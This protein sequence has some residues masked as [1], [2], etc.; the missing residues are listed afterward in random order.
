M[1]YQAII[2]IGLVIFML[3]LIL[4]LRSLKTPPTKSKV[5][6]D[7]PL[8]SV[9][10]PARDE[11]ANIKTCLESLQKQDY[12]NFEIL[13]LDDNSSDGT[14]DIVRRIAAT[15]D[16]I[17]L[18]EGKL[19]PKGWAGKSYACYQ[20]AKKAKGSWLLFTDA[21]TMHAPHTLRSSLAL[22]I[23]HNASLLS[24][25]PRQITTSLQQK[26]TIPVIYFIIMSWF[27]LWWLQRSGHPRPS[28]AIG[29]F[30]LFPTKAYW[31]CGGHKAVKTRIV[32]DVWLGIEVNRH[33]GRHIAVDLS[34][35][36]SCHMYNDIGAIWKGLAKAIYSVAAVSKWG[37]AGLLVAGYAFFLA[38]FYW[39]W[40]ELFVVATPSDWRLIIIF[41]V[42]TVLAMRWLVDK[43]F[44]ESIISTITH[45][46]GFAF[47]ILNVL[48]AGSRQAVGAGVQWK[49]RLYSK[50]SS[51]T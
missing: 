51:I 7:E 24:G 44:K 33:G 19:L 37:L 27:P 50:E 11:E 16:R 29:Q 15:D 36:V 6:Q 39:L 1:L 32:E 14:A 25:F 13:V 2:A 48:Y 4:N 10:I 38:P 22:A 9:L 42:S 40:N 28:L 21:D 18:L 49:E 20:L 47:L 41:Q 26:I 30:L 23:K 45:P 35:I 31:E 46:L 43:H 3:N 17:Q 12:P 5:P 34:P 8:I